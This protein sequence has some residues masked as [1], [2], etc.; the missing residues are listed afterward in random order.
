[1][2]CKTLLLFITLGTNLGTQGY[3]IES[4]VVE[5]PN[6]KIQGLQLTTFA[7]KTYYSFQKIPY[8]SPPVG[9]LRFKAPQPAQNWDGI[10]NATFL[11]TSCYQLQ[12]NQVSDS[13]DCLFINV[14]TPELP[15]DDQNVS[16]PVMF[17][18][19]GGAFL[20]GSSILA[21]PDLFVNNGV[22]LVSFNYRLGA[23]GFLSTQDEVIP[24]NNGLKD[25]LLALQWTHQNIHLFGGNPDKITIF[26][27]SAGSASVAYQMLNQ[28]SVGLFAGAILESGSFL[29]PWAFQR[30]SR[31]IAFNTAAILNS[32]FSSSNDST[33]LLAFLQGVAAE[34]L[35]AAAE[36]YL[37]N[38]TTPWDYAVSQGN[39]FAPVIEVKNPDAFL[40]R[41]MYGLLQAGNIIKVPVMI[42]FNS[43][44]SLLFNQDPAV[45]QTVL[46]AWDAKLDLIVPNDMQITDLEKHSEMALSIRDIYT[47]GETFGNRLGDG[48]RYCSDNSFTR[49]IIKHAEFYSTLAETYFYQFSYDGK[50]G[51]ISV[52]YDGAESVGHSEEAFYLFCSGL[53]CNFDSYVPESDRITSERLIKLWTDFA[54]FQNPT[55]EVSELLQNITWPPLSVVDGDFLYLDVNENLEIKNHPKSATFDEWDKL[56]ENLGYSDFDTY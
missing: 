51:N 35:D 22:I 42:G 29:S 56:Y 39:L 32:T 26:G 17:F 6:G 48:I 33:A 43:E 18:I 23:F 20:L 47:G 46:E 1:M 44:E 13:E 2:L 3:F 50:L 38:Q 12:I 24:G 10:L 30:N 9:T 15:T 25:Q 49:S 7:N 31:Q 41:K 55:P 40:T 16:L 45:F 8:A 21:P 5:L 34:D 11:A 37:I 54:K 28:D 36:Q 4:P 52:H 14:Y 19:Y 53:G 27:Q